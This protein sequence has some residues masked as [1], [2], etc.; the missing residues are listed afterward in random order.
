MKSRLYTKYEKEIRPALKEKF[1]FKN[2]MA[3]PKILKVT[4]NSGI[5]ARGGDN[6]F[7]D[8]VEETLMKVTG[9][10]PIKTKAKKAISAFKVREG[11]VVGATVTLRGQRMFDFLDKLVNISI[12]RIRDFRG[13]PVKN[14]DKQGNLN[15]GLKEHTVFPEIKADELEKV[16]G[17]QI[18]VTTNA[19]NYEEGLELF[20][21]LGFPFQK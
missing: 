4:V 21:L 15:L 2:E 10:K 3:I 19:S 1:G 14:V 18:A 6:H 9:Q 5:N 13:L 16:H 17:L 12:P 20:K 11:M 7:V 8:V